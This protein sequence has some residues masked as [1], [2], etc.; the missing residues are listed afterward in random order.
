M[1]NI[2]NPQ[3]SLTLIPLG[4]IGNVTKN[5]YLY[6][7]GND[8][9]IVDCGMGFPDAST[10]GVDFLIP[11]I[12]HLKKL[13]TQGKR[14]VGLLLTHGHEDHIGGVPFVLDQLPEF[15]I[16]ATALT[17]AFTN[18]KLR[19]FGLNR[20]VNDVEFK[21]EIV[22]GSFKVRFLHIT[23]SVMDTSNIFIK[24]PVGNFYHG[25]DYK[26]DL[27]PP[28]D[29]PSDIH[30]IAD[31]A[32]EGVLCMLSDCLGAEREGHS[33]SERKISDSFESEF[34]RA[35]GRIYVSTYSSNL[36]RMNQ[37]IEV[38]LKFNKKICF[39]G[40]S[41]IKARDIGRQLGYMK[42]PPN[43]EVKPQQ[44]MGMDPTK[45]MI[46]IPGSQAQEESA[47]V[48]VAND[49]HKDLRIDKNDTVIFSAD[50]IPGNEVNIYNLIDT[51]SKK[52][53]KVIHSDMTDEFHVSGHGAQNDIKLLATLTQPKFA[54]PI[55]GN[56]RH[57]LAF[58][59]LMTELGMHERDIVIPEYGQ[60]VIFTPN[61][62]RYGAK[63][64]LATVYVDEI[65]GEEMEKYVLL[66]RQKI[67]KEGIMIVMVEVQGE[68]G[69]VLNEPDIIVRGVAFPEKEAFSKKLSDELKRSFGQKDT[70]ATNFA[71]HR[72]SIQRAAENILYRMK[73]E[74]LVIPIVI[75]V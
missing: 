71:V 10:P 55:G 63:V 8:I 45:V 3:N 46:L 60:E 11:D 61:S 73:R 21:K 5:M 18:E 22:L 17:A 57:M 15:P 67:I 36:S 59:G 35:K 75:E 9:L 33:K 31:T 40:R 6:I 43:M 47:L 41:F 66:D 7:Y 34:R 37:A 1:D 4:G 50:P 24:S 69:K 13:V 44:V 53:A 74:P 72:K 2:I 64:P 20:R 16:Y 68:T 54:F 56:F 19:D 62:F 65:T 52:G 58:R 48:R 12:T 29:K 51:L 28:D 32:R 39:I 23:H 26:F 70:K 38:A 49:D 27:T 25:S 42:L 30:G 14:I